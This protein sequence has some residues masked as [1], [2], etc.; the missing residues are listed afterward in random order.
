MYVFS[1]GCFKFCLVF[2]RIVTLGGELENCYVNTEST[3]WKQDRLAYG[4]WR[5]CLLPVLM[6][7]I[8][9]FKKCPDYW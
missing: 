3:F 1:Q 6:L 8:D 2:L 9:E 7:R 4:L 5:W